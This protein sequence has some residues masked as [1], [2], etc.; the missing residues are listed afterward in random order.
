LRQL[1]ALTALFFKAYV[2][3]RG[4]LFFS[5]LVPIIITGIFGILTF[6]GENTTGV[7]IADEARNE[8]SA[9]FVAT[10]KQID[11]LAVSEGDRE[12][13][14]RALRKDDRSL[15]IVFPPDFA[16]SPQRSATILI[17]AHAG[18]PQ[19]AAIAESVLTRVLNEASFSAL[20]AQ[21]L[22]RLQ[23]QEVEAQRL[24]YVDFL[25]PGMVAMSVMQLGLFSV[26]FG[27]V[28]QK[29]L[30]V[31]RRLMATPLP[32]RTYFAASTA[33]RLLMT[34]L[35]VIILVGMGVLFFRFTL[36]GNFG[37][38][39]AVAVL[40]G[41][42]FLTH[43]FALAGRARTEDQAAPVANLLSFP[44]MFLSGIFFPRENVPDW[45]RPVTD[46]LPLTF[47]ADAAR[48][49]AT[50]GAHLWDVGGDLLGLAVWGVIGFVFAVRFFRFE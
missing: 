4:A 44:Q 39:I 48:A 17:Y 26:A 2:R 9:R 32:A 45:L 22:A 14:L 43:G 40:G 33:T 16:P 23:R 29:R 3:D 21:P 15:V 30:G 5:L 19:Q 42:V 34:V 24:T 25:I 1:A 7:G 38:L 20:G 46:L 12:S 36:L 47:F 50:E 27:V 31:L 41:G 10:L 37:E 28:Q 49:I 35:Q 8:A 11:L 18:R 13:E 6:G